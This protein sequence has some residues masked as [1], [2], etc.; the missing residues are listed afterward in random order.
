VRQP[1]LGGEADRGVAG[2]EAVTAL[3]LD[4]LEE[5]AAAWRDVGLTDDPAVI[6]AK[7]NISAFILAKARTHSSA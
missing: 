1:G 4:D 6:L 5:A 7:A 2:A 3:A